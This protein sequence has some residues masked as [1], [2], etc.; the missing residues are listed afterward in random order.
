MVV[1]GIDG[2]LHVA[3]GTDPRA[4]ETISVAVRAAVRAVVRSGAHVVLCTG[5]LSPATLPFL[6]ELG[7]SAGFGGCSTGA[8]LIAAATGH[9]FGQVAFDLLDPIAVLREHLP[10]AVFVAE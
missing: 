4:H 5:R 10:G 9:V 7:V 1:L 2:T 8:M 6:R 3:P